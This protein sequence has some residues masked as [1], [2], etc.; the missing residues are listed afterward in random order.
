MDSPDLS[1]QEALPW[2]EIVGKAVHDMKTPLSSL[3][4]TLEI[5]R[6]TSGGSEAHG[7]LIAMLDNQVNEL[8]RQLDTLANDPAAILSR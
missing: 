5:L 7:K 2:K 3:R 1:Q 6:M 4:V 8:A